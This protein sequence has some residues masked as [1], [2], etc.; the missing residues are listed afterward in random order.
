MR[1]TTQP[2]TVCSLLC[3]STVLGS[4]NADRHEGDASPLIAIILFKSSV[5]SCCPNLPGASRPRLCPSP[6]W[7][8]THPEPQSGQTPFQPNSILDMPASMVPRMVTQGKPGF[9]RPASGEGLKRSFH[10]CFFHWERSRKLPGSRNS[11]TP[12]EASSVLAG[13]FEGR[14]LVNLL[15]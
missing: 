14:Q 8:P 1:D 7:T 15:E 13:T 4:G 5:F 12:P 6:T 11:E 3:A 10:F 2:R 9:P